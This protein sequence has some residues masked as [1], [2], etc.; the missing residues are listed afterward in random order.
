MCK[1]CIRIEQMH[2]KYVGN[3]LTQ[4]KAEEKK[5]LMNCPL[6]WALEAVN[7]NDSVYLRV[8]M[9]LTWGLPDK[10]HDKMHEE[11]RR[12]GRY[13]ERGWSNTQ[14]QKDGLSSTSTQMPL[15][16]ST[17]HP[18]HR[19]I[20]VLQ[21]V[22]TFSQFGSEM[23]VQNIFSLIALRR[24]FQPGSSLSSLLSWWL[25]NM[26][27]KLS[28]Y[29]NNWFFLIN[30]GHATLKFKVNKMKGAFKSHLGASSIH[31]TSSTTP[32]ITVKVYCQKQLTLWTIRVFP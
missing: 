21:S 5:K 11:R 26:I 20:L 2:C 12:P 19:V 9:L 30:Q 6:N 7:H 14:G 31:P 25:T 28:V 18:Q 1:H 4:S 15:T 10:A 24:L 27:W 16:L 32:L 3:K 22:A 8:G 23:S 13:M 29:W 17:L